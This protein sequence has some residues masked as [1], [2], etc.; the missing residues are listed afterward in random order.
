MFRLDVPPYTTKRKTQGARHRKNEEGRRRASP[1][2][3]GTIQVPQGGRAGPPGGS[4][5]GI[6]AG[7]GPFTAMLHLWQGIL[8][9]AANLFSRRGPQPPTAVNKTKAEGVTSEQ[10]RK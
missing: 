6:R 2:V 7:L 10:D 5:S 3:P 8:S 1:A 4:D 9:S